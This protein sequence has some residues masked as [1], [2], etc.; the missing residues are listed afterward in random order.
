MAKV[1]KKKED[2]PEVD[3]T[4]SMDFDLGEPVVIPVNIK[5]KDGVLRSYELR[6]ANGDSACR[7]KNAIL[8]RTNLGPNGKPSSFGAIADTEPIVISLCLFDK[9]G[10][11]VPVGVIRQW[12]AKVQR[13]LFE[14]AKEISELDEDEELK[15]TVKNGQ[16]DTTDGS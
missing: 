13:A 14:K 2:T 4:R 9:D 1:T 3:T 8:Q 11:N 12:P 15:D 10:K 5:D 16:T 7:W 6:E